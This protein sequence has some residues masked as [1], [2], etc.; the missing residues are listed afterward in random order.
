MNITGRSFLR[1]EMKVAELVGE[2]PSLLLLL[3]HFGIR[4]ALNENSVR[5]ICTISN[6]DERVFIT[7]CSLYMGH[8]LDKRYELQVSDIPHLINYLRNSH[9][10]YK[11]EKYPEITSYIHSLKENE[12]SLELE[13]VEKFFN[14]YFAEVIEHLD[15]EEKTAFP[16]FDSVAEGNYGAANEF[17]AMVYLEHHSD[18]ELKLEDLMNLLLKHIT[19]RNSIQLRRK[20][21]QSLFELEYDLKVHSMVEELIL[22]PLARKAEMRNGNAK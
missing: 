16:Y 5:D 19:I 9:S 8:P 14:D 1:P 11:N 13:M 22:I 6:T 21:L 4:E 3:E 2:N 10:Y 17:S 18:I 12:G 20:L 15:Y 7:I